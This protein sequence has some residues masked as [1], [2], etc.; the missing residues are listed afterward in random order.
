MEKE[1]TVTLVHRNEL[2][3]FQVGLSILDLLKRAKVKPQLT[4]ILVVTVMTLRRAG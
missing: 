2:F 4:E 1:L 3:A